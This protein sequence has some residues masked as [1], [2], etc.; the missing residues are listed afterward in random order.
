MA[1]AG[2]LTL[3]AETLLLKF[4]RDL[5]SLGIIQPSQTIDYT[6]CMTMTEWRI[7]YQKLVTKMHFFFNMKLSGKQSSDSVGGR[8]KACSHLKVLYP[9]LSDVELHTHTN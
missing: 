5:S 8:D 2:S 9:A 4:Y 6:F 7:K 1:A 3:Q